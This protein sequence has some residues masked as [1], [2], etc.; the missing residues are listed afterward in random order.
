MKVLHP[1]S[2]NKSLR[3]CQSLHSRNVVVAFRFS[4]NILRWLPT[5]EIVARQ[6]TKY[7]FNLQVLIQGKERDAKILVGS[8]PQIPEME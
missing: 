1:Q 2:F 3:P 4:P 6:N 5:A 7:Y 8:Q